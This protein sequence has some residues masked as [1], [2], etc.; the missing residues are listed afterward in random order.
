V[1]KTRQKAVEKTGKTREK[2][3]KSW[4]IMGKYRGKKYTY[5]Y[6]YMRIMGKSCCKWM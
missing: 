4:E 3:G 2:L 6:I 1:E 5:I